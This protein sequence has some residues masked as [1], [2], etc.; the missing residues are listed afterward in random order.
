MDKQHT[1]SYPADIGVLFMRRTIPYWQMAGFFFTSVVGTL[2]H[3]LFDWTG[4]STIAA[5]FSAVNESI[6]EHLKLLFYP[7]LAFA[8]IE[9]W[10]WGKDTASFWC[11]KL[12]SIL[13]GLLLIPVAYYTYTGALGIKADWLNIALFFMVAGLVYWVETKWFLSG[14]KYAIGNTLSLILLC[15]IAIVF[16]ILTFAPIRIPLLRDPLSGTYGIQ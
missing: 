15:L 6:W 4:G 3:F 5:L 16:T 11:I 9:Y 2:L 7:M 10:A 1:I 8:F 13:F 14:R 12:W